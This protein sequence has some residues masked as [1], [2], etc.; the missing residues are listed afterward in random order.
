MFY[1]YQLIDPR[2]DKVFYIGKGQRGR[3]WQHER[4]A[5][6]GDVDCNWAKYHTIR[7]IVAEGLTV[8][9][10]IVE[11]FDIETEAYNFEEILIHGTP[12]I[13]NIHQGGEIMR[14]LFKMPDSDKYR[15]EINAWLAK[16]PEIS[17]QV[18]IKRKENRPIDDLPKWMRRNVTVKF[19]EGPHSGTFGKVSK[20]LEDL[21]V[22]VVVP[23]YKGMSFVDTHL[24]T[25]Q[26]AEE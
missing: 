16:A 7:A 22:C 14:N 13:T 10:N 19:I 3:A 2:N 20:M 17:S 12:G 1:V 24:D 18:E 8:T 21:M 9:V 25:I 23:H 4:N 5:R 6:N 26:F 11:E 15:P